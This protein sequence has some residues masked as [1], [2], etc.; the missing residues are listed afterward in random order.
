VL[1]AR[2]APAWGEASKESKPTTVFAAP[3]PDGTVDGDRRASSRN[4]GTGECGDVRKVAVTLV[5][6]EAVADREPIVD[7]EADVPRRQ[8]DLA[9]I[10]LRQ[11][12][13]DLE[14]RRPAGA[15]AAQKVLE[16]QAGVDDVLDDQDVAEP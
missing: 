3:Q 1:L 13:A 10:G 15:E 14:C 12:G 16:G 7:L 5:V 2:S 6:V 11:Q 8:L 9:A 4:L